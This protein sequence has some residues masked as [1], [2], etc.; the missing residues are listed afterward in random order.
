MTPHCADQ[1]PEY[2]DRAM[3]ILS[4]NLDAFMSGKPLKNVCDKKA[5]Y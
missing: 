5:G 3:D 2:L 4:Y 1:D